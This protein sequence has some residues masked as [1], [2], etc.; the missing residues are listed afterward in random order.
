MKMKDDLAAKIIETHRDV[1][2]ICRT[3]EEMKET[4][5]D[6]EARIRALEGWRAEKTG[7]EKRLGG[8]CAGLSGVTGGIVAWLFQYV[9]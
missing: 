8:V 2:W 1:K 7:A 5:A 6:F 9:G 3:L 4:D